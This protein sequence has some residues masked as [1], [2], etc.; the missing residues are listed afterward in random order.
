LHS[1]VETC[2]VKNGHKAGDKAICSEILKLINSIA[3]KEELF[4]QWKESIT[5]PI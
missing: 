5:V 1:D 4:Q 2:F 3:Q